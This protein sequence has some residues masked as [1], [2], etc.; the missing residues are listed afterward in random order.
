MAGK[1]KSKVSQIS[2]YKCTNSMNI[3][4]YSENNLHNYIA[5]SIAHQKT[6]DSGCWLG[7]DE[8]GRGPVL[9]ESKKRCFNFNK[10]FFSLTDAVS[11][12]F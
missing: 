7:I 6:K 9:G 4:E 3:D 8:A 1:S 2:Y 11:K 5:E 10:K 12:L